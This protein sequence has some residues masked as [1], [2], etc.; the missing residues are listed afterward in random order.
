MESGSVPSEWVISNPDSG[1]GFEVYN[2]GTCTDNGNQVIGLQTWAAFPSLTTTDAIFTQV[3]DLT[4]YDDA[5]LEFDVA[6][7]HWYTNVNT[8][9][10]IAVSILL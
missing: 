1:V 8:I 3:V 7:A 2:I 4:A 10:D 9:L 6:Y 5:Q